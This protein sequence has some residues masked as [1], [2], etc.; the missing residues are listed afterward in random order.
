MANLVN[1]IDERGKMDHTRW[2]TQCERK[3][4]SNLGRH[5]DEAVCAK[6][7]KLIIGYIRGLHYRQNWDVLNKS[8]VLT[9]ALAER[10]DA[11]ERQQIV[12]MLTNSDLSI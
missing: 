7:I 4:I 10:D 9:H 2:T 1:T 8:E 11:T 5:R 6:R 12:A 3:F